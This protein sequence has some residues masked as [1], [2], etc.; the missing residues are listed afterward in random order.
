MPTGDGSGKKLRGLLKE[1]HDF[2]KKPNFNRK[3]YWPVNGGTHKLSS[4]LVN[5]DSWPMGV[6]GVCG[7]CV[8]GGRQRN[9]RTARERAG[10]R[11]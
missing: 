9:R 3:G 2:V 5:V 8:G 1:H 4:H 11:E 10:S 7:C 6:L